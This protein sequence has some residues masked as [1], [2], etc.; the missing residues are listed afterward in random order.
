MDLE[1]AVV[2]VGLAGKKRFQLQARGF[3][4]ELG[5]RRFRLAHHALVLLRLAERNQFLVVVEPLFDALEGV[6][7]VAERGAL[8]HQLGGL[9]RVVPELGIFGE[10]VQFGEALFRFF[11]V[12]APSSAAPRT[13]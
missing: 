9:L 12:K 13:A 10:P 5:E 4:L 1:I 3:V 7:L 2:G 6:E 8:L 11:D